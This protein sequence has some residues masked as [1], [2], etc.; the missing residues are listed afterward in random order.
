MK[1]QC[2]NLDKCGFFLN[3]RGNN[4]VRRNNWVL[5]FCEDKESSDTCARKK[6]KIETGKS[7]VDNMS[8]SGKILF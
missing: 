8:P 2:E 4:E 5:M 7:P 3:Y 1:E 6:V